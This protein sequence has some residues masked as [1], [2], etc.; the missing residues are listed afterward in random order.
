M[1]STKPISKYDKREILQMTMEFFTAI[2]NVE[3][4]ISTTTVLIR[5]TDLPPFTTLFRPII[6]TMKNKFYYLHSISHISLLCTTYLIQIQN[7]ISFRMQELKIE[8]FYTKER[9]KNVNEW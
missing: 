2:L 8:T 1:T 7:S 5:Q 3:L 4:F 6:N 9:C